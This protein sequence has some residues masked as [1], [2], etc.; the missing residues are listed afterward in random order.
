MSTQRI[1]PL[2]DNGCLFLFIHIHCE[3][4]RS[5]LTPFQQQASTLRQMAL[6]RMLV[7]VSTIFILTASPIVAL[8]I[9]TTVVYDFF[10]SRRYTNIFLLCYLV[11]LELGMINSSGI[12]FFVYVLRS[13]RF[14][15]E[16]A[17][18]ACFRFLK[19]DK[20]GVNKK[21]VIVKTTTT[22]KSSVSR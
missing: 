8:N 16:L 20:A 1:T 7:I 4:K 10:I 11:Y 17:T 18:F 12:N 19:H 3:L 14:R 6:A 13:S 9:T 15:Q 21:D 5:P 22:G 2:N